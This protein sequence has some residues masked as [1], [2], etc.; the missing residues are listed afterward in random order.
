MAVPNVTFVRKE[1][2]KLLSQYNLIRDVI[3]G[4]TSVKDEGAKY[5]PIPNSSDKSPENM[6]RYRAYK[7]RAVFYNVARRTLN[8]MVGHVF[9]KDPVIKIPTILEPITTNA[10]GAGITLTQLAKKTVSLTLAYSRCGLFVDYPMVS[11]ENVPSRDDLLS[12]RIRP[13]IN[14]FSPH[15]IINWRVIQRGSEE[16]LSLVVIFEL[17]VAH[18]DGFEIKE[19]GQYRVLRLDDSGNCIQQIW[20]ESV[21]TE[22]KDDNKKRTFD[23]YE[24]FIMRGPDGAPL[25]HIPFTFVGSENN[26]HAPDNPNFYD[27]CSLNIAHY[28]NSADYEE[29]CY[30]C[31]QATPVCTGLTEAWVNETLKGRLDMGSVGGI[32]LPDGATFALHQAQPNG[33]IK[34]AMDAKER[35]MVALGAKLVEQSSVQRTATEATLES[36]SE[37]SI[38]ASVSKNVSVAI[39][40]ALKECSM[41]MGISDDIEYKLNS[42]FDITKLSPE[43]TKELVNAWMNKAIS[44]SEMR[45]ELNKSGIATLTDEEALLQIQNDIILNS[46]AT[47]EV[48]EIQ[49]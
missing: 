11:D 1:H 49:Q 35:Q 32:P 44:F 41:F 33:M 24:E 42:D 20:R 15:S 3:S 22:Y 9:A 25:D 6:E 30:I 18:D 13:T 31:G 5:L 39:E 36:T 26:D 21:P 34:E 16:I 45:M 4:E 28:R 47:E 37:N 43:S 8:G 19:A 14:V 17:Y 7:T 38:L 46:I 27:I 40:W 2:V 10:T 23:A 48:K 12:G 29:S